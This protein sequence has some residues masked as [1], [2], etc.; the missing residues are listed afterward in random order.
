MRSYT[1]A[2]LLSVF[3]MAGIV[4][5]ASRLLPGGLSRLAQR[6]LRGSDHDVSD[7]S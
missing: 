4:A 6:R 3:V 7:R 2:A 5:L 1:V